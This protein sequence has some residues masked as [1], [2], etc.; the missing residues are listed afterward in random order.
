M[1]SISF[2]DRIEELYP[3]FFIDLI[4]RINA[5]AN[6]QKKIT[7]REDNLESFYRY[8]VQRP[9]AISNLSIWG[10]KRGVYHLELVYRGLFLRFK[11]V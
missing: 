11:L 6:S 3:I 7:S 10:W 5:I 9:V 4:S 2:G 1:Y 8:I